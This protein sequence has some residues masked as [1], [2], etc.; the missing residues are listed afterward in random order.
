MKKRLFVFLFCCI[1]F[2]NSYA[3]VK[4]QPGVRAGLNISKL[5]GIDISSK[6][7][8]YFGLYGGIN[9]SNI[10]TLQPELSYSRQG[11]QG[12]YSFN[13]YVI[14]GQ[15]TQMYHYNTFLSQ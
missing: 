2:L 7:D 1:T 6:K 13:Y 14:L 8:I 9:F 10:Y 5:Q 4:F 12:I 3:Q 15:G 11:A